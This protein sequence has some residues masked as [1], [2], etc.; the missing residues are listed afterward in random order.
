MKTTEQKPEASPALAVTLC[1]PVL[2]LWEA[3]ERDGP[4]CAC[5][6]FRELAENCDAFENGIDRV[7]QSTVRVS[8]E[9]IHTLLA[10]GPVF[11]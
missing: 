10:G 3:Y 11:R 5:Y 4:G 8:P 6:L 1:S 2:A 7:V 9:E